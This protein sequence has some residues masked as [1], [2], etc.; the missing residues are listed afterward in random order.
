LV[1]QDFRGLPT[2]FAPLAKQLVEVSMPHEIDSVSSFISMLDQWKVELRLK[3]ETWNPWYRGQDDAE[4]CLLPSIYRLGDGRYFERELLRDFE[5]HLST[6][7]NFNPKN[8]IEW[9]F[10]AQHHGLP[11]RMLDWSE[12]PLVALFFAVESYDNGKDG[13]IF[14]LH[15]AEF[16]KRV[17]FSSSNN[18][19]EEAVTKEGFIS[20]PTTDNHFFHKYVL[21]LTGLDVQRKPEAKLPMAFRPKSYFKRSMSQSGVFTIHGT[22]KKPLEDFK[23][24]G[25]NIIENKVPSAHKRTIFRELFDLAI[26]HGS[27]FGDPNSIAKSLKYRYFDYLTPET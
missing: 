6:E 27:L 12:N 22:D 9:I 24:Y 1:F 8:D 17:A 21:N 11:T 20:V 13:K 26:S 18:V 10:I 19:F 15:P 3:G 14:A 16:N 5:I 7:A 25:I 4:W 2:R 23:S